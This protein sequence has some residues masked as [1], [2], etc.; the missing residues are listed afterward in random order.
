MPSHLR[1]YDEPGD[2]HFWTISCYRRLGFFHH[3]A[4]KQVVIEA[5]DML[6]RKFRVCLVGYVVMPDHVRFRVYPHSRGSR[7]PLP[8][9]S[10]LHA[11]KKHVGYYAKEKLREVWRTHGKLWS[12]PMNHW[13]LGRHDK[14]SIWNVR[15]HDFNIDQQKTLI[16]KLEYCHANPVTRGL[17]D[18]AEDWPWSSYR[19][20]EKLDGVVLE[21]DWDGAWPIEW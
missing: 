19:Y 7:E 21:C 13:A 4:T 18:L 15:G 14:Q 10:L 6:R 12:E 17:V 2:I 9:S 8:I 1:R 3:D 20:Y 5:L 11:F 16:Q